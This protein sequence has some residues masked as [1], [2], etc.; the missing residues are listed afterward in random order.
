MGSIP[1]ISSNLQQPTSKVNSELRHSGCCSNKTAMASP[2]VTWW[3]PW[4]FSMETPWK[5]MGNMLFFQNSG[6]F[7]WARWKDLPFL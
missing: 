7:R 4:G 5:T 6:D 3:C 1:E 2:G